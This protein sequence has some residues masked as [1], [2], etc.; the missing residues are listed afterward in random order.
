M[1]FLVLIFLL[2]SVGSPVTSN[3][4]SRIHRAVD[5]LVSHYN[6]EVGLIYESEDEGV[7]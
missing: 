3:K 6:P 1:R 7:H 5:Y 4:D 2:I